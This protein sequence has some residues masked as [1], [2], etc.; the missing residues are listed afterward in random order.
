MYRKKIRLLGAAALLGFAVHQNANAVPVDIAF[1]VDQS[2]SMPGEFVWIPNVITQIDAALQTQSSITSTR[3]GFAGFMVNAGN[4]GMCAS[5]G[6]GDELCDLAY[7]DM[8]SNITD[9]ENAAIAAR[10]DLRR[11]TERGYHAADWSRENFSWADDAVKIMILI[12]D[13]RGDQGSTIPDVGP[14]N[15]EQDL[16]QLLD[17]GDFLLN[18]I[19]QTSNWRDWDEAV[20]DINDPGYQGLFDLAFLRDNPIDFTQQFVDAKVEEIVSVIP[21]PAAVWLF[22]TALIGL[23]GFGKRGKAS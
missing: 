8:T 20:F 10:G 9:I 4:E 14:G 16:G 23:I 13:E 15:K 1:I 12:M 17:D 5:S 3:Y 22:G 19:T 6:P 21:V 2:L 11:N 7:V 18:V